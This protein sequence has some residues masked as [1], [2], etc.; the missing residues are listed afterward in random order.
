MYL[1]FQEEL[2]SIVTITHKDL[3]LNYYFLQ[4][5]VQDHHLVLD[6]RFVSKI[7][8]IYNTYNLVH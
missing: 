6:D 4:M 2:P 8:L 3:K 1:I 7:T 5:Y